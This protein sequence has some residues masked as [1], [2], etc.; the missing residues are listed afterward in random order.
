MT[1]VAIGAAIYA[2]SREWNSSGTKRKPTRASVISC[3]DLGVKFDYPARTTNDAA[4]LRIGAEARAVADR[5]SV[6]VDASG[7]GWTSGRIAVTY[8]LVVDVPL[9]DLGENNFLVTVFDSSGLPILDAT[10][11]FAITRT[12]ATVAA[13]PATQTISVKVRAGATRLR[14]A[15]QPLII[16]GTPLPTRGSEKLRAAFSIGAD[17]PGSIDLE[18]F[19]DEGAPDPELNLAVGSFR[20]SHRDLPEGMQ[21]KEGDPVIFHWAMDDSGLLTATV[22]LP[23]LRQT[24]ATKRFYVDQAGHRS[25]EGEEGDK[26]VGTAIST[27][28][29]EAAEVVEAV[30]VSA[31]DELAEI[32]RKLEE[33]RRKLK[34]ASSGDE[35]RSIT[36]N[37]RHIRQETAHLRTRPDNRCRYLQHKLDDLERRFNAEARHEPPT[38]DTER[39]DRQFIVASNEIQ[40][41][42]PA[43]LDIA[44]VILDEMEGLYWRTLWK[45]K[46]FVINVFAQC[47]KQRYLAADK[48]AF[49]LLVSDGE[50]AIRANDIDELRGVIR[51]IW[52]SQM[53]ATTAA[54]DTSK[55]AAVLRG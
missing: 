14:N 50:N 33:Q 8:E 51:Q 25:F 34:E 55:L 47:A 52:N 48:A 4:K 41:R 38:P 23:S 26:L 46:E 30:G 22:E 15:L 49:D 24:F 39:F 28:E 5:L 29:A 1:A 3:K 37:V 53:V 2:E 18:L 13:I 42:T 36:E 44:E 35:R 43:S 21:I 17:L 9:R 45:N 11:T 54:S 12:H 16:K 7:H 27:A 10:T 6:Q 40:R 31:T 19:Q 20:I 32:E